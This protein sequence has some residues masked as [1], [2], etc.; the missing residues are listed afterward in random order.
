MK[1][2]PELLV[3]AGKRGLRIDLQM[4]AEIDQ[5]KEQVAEFVL[6]LG[7]AG[8]AHCF[9]KLGDFFLDFVQDRFGLAPVEAYA[10]G[11]LLEFQCPCQRRKGYRDTVEKTLAVILGVEP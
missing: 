4:P 8:C 5:G 1:A 11:F 6:D 10:R 9:T 3:R 7:F 2:R